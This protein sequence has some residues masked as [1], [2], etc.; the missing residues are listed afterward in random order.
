[1][2]VALKTVLQSGSSCEIGSFHS[3]VAKY[4]SLL[5]CDAVLL[6]NS[7]WHVKGLYCLHLQGIFPVKTSSDVFLS[8]IFLTAAGVLSVPLFTAAVSTPVELHEHYSSPLQEVIQ[9]AQHSQC[10]DKAV[11]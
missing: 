10:S 6:A 2:C 3:D 4:S 5:G 11:M 7:S 9:P 8:Y 1:L